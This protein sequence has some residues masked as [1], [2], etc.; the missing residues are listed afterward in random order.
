MTLVLLLVYCNYFNV[1]LAFCFFRRK[2]CKVTAT[3][4]FPQIFQELFFARVPCLPLQ[5]GCFPKASAKVDTF[6]QSTKPFNIFFQENFSPISQSPETPHFTSLTF[7]T[8]SCG[9]RGVGG[10]NGAQSIA[11]AFARSHYFPA[12]GCSPHIQIRAL[13]I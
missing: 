2:F 8:D 1:L 6:H 11:I 13:Y 7:F 10:A 5:A 4:S 3:F 9:M 12:Q